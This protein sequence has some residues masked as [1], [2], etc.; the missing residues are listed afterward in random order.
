MKTFWRRITCATTLAALSFLMTLPFPAQTAALLGGPAI[1][2]SY[3]S[4]QNP[5]FPPLPYDPFPDLPVVVVDEHTII[6]QDQEVDYA[7]LRAEGAAVEA[8]RRLTEPRE[9]LSSQ[10]PC[11]LWLE[12]LPYRN[13]LT[14][15]LHNTIPGRTYQILSRENVVTGSWLDEATAIGENGQDYTTVP[16]PMNGRATLFFRVLEIGPNRIQTENAITGTKDWLLNNPA[17]FRPVIRLVKLSDIQ[18]GEELEWQGW[19]SAEDDMVPEI[20]GFASATSVNTGNMLD[21]YVDVRNGDPNFTIDIYRM[22]WY[23]GLGARKMGS[24]ITL[25]SVKQPV[26]GMDPATGLVDCLLPAPANPNGP[27]QSSY[28]FTVP[29]DWV[30][31]VYLAKLTTMPTGKQ[32]YIHFVVRD[33]Y[34]PS[35]F[36]FQCSV[37]TYQAYNP[38]G[39]NSVYPYPRNQACSAKQLDCLDCQ[40]ATKVSF[41]RPYAGP[42]CDVRLNYGTGA[43]EFLV[44]VTQYPRVG[45]EYNM[46]RWL[47]RQGYDVTYC[48]SVDT[49]RGWPSNKGFKTFLS[50]GH[51]EYWSGPM[52]ANVEGARDGGV[53]LAFFSA[54]NCWWKVNFDPGER[55]F[56][57]NKSDNTDLWRGSSVGNPE[58][59]MIGVEFLYNTIEG[60]IMISDPMP[61]HWVYEHTGLNQGDTLNGLLGIEVDGFWDTYNPESSRPTPPPGTIVLASSPFNTG[62]DA[63]CEGAPAILDCSASERI[64]AR[65]GH[66]DMTIYTAASGAQVFATGSMNWNW[67]LDDFA[68]G[69]Q[70]P[71]NIG[72]PSPWGASRVNSKAQQMTHNVLRTF[73]GKNTV[74]NTILNTDATTSGNW[75]GIYGTEAYRIAASTP[76]SSGSPDFATIIGAELFVLADPSTDSR[77]LSKHLPS[78]GRVAAAW[79]TTASQGAYYTIDVKLDDDIHQVGL[80]CVDWL[81]TGS[82]LQK[83]EVFDYPDTSNPLDVREVQLPLNGVY[84]TWKFGGHKTIRVTKTDRNIVNRAMVSAV[85]IDAIP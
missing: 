27:W 23:G 20:Q 74:N 65:P 81:G 68:W 32:S 4:A 6:Y 59:S 37:S 83:I 48:T 36:L 29:C 33:D 2:I 26:P 85:F 16:I 77:A 49:H 9:A 3:Y 40:H 69:T 38:W 66:S 28:S 64:T 60:A 25:A 84:F 78:T 76:I 31:G 53:S 46:V 56:S 12:V 17:S 21:L 13:P 55:A 50:V 61:D 35:D 70:I 11:H 47:E 5:D 71:W 10:D 34:R 72:N 22:G 79:T 63:V 73:S 51:D 82:I 19:P 7:A 30:S 45:W 43:G 14:I 41:N 54:N 15:V 67:G 24:T 75:Q 44:M 58:I 1:G 42:G 80:Y 8:A 57:V 18:I 39:G 52:R 62:N